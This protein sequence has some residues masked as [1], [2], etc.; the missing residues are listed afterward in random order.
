MGILTSRRAQGKGNLLAQE[1]GE[2]SP[3]P[4]LTPTGHHRQ[5]MLPDTSPF[6]YARF[7]KRGGG[8]DTHPGLTD[9][10][11]G[12]FL[13]IFYHCHQHVIACDLPKMY[14]G[15]KAGSDVLQHCSSE[16]AGRPSPQPPC[17][18]DT[19][20]FLHQAAPDQ[21]YVTGVSRFIWKK[22]FSE[23]SLLC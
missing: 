5:Q 1:V 19:G 8:C 7:W 21:P 10:R 9:S 14:P 6:C 18:L 11:D 12:G 17:V 3:D 16:T 2:M 13:Q 20:F 23:A 4:Q 15:N 22:L